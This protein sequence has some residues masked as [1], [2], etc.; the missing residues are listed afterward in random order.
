VSRFPAR[1][2]GRW[3][4]LSGLVTLTACAGQTPVAGPS[5]SVS[6]GTEEKGSPAAKKEVW[7][8]TWDDRNTNPTLGVVSRSEGNIILTVAPDGSVTGEGSA[9][10]TTEGGSKDYDIRISG[11]RDEDAFRLDWTGPGGTINIVVPIEGTT[12]NG[13][14]RVGTGG[15]YY[16]WETSLDCINCEA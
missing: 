6:I 16:F 8:G 9:T 11:R 12:A 10:Q 1:S 13:K 2:A 5:P 3:L 4:L 15:I 7:E 14:G